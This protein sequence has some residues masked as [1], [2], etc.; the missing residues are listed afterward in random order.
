MGTE[1]FRSDRLGDSLGSKLSHSELSVGRKNEALGSRL[2]LLV[3]VVFSE[4][5]EDRDSHF[6]VSSRMVFEPG[7]GVVFDVFRGPKGKSEG[8]C[9]SGDSVLEYFFSKVDHFESSIFL[10][11]LSDI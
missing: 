9:P 1:N 4:V 10:R 2:G 6:S 8:L 11:T 7:L 3:G 5:R